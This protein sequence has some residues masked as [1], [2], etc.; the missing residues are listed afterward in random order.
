MKYFTS[1]RSLR[2]T[3]TKRAMKKAESLDMPINMYVYV[4]ERM[5]G[6][7]WA[8]NQP[9]VL[10]CCVIDDGPLLIV[11]AQLDLCSCNRSNTYKQTH[12]VRGKLCIWLRA[13]VKG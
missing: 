12:D 6:G 13:Q 9:G 4:L 1:K 5:L 11:G 7:R 8:D 2:Q 10:C 3:L